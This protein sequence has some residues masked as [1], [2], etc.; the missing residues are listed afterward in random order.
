MGVVYRAE[1]TKLGRQVAIKVLPDV[2]AKDP[3]RLARFE[4][5]AKVLPS[6]NQRIGVGAAPLVRPPGGAHGGAPLQI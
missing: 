1:D 2:F 5:E 4:R 6:L 3:G